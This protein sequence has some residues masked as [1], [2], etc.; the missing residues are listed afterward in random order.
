MHCGKRPESRYIFHHDDSCATW[1]NRMPSKGTTLPRLRSVAAA[2]AILPRL[3]WVTYSGRNSFLPGLAVPSPSVVLTRA[4]HTMTRG[5]LPLRGGRLIDLTLRVACLRGALGETSY[6]EIRHPRDSP[7]WRKEDRDGCPQ[8]V[9]RVVSG[10]P[11]HCLLPEWPIG[12][13]RP[14]CVARI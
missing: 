9:K 10:V 3:G 2:R 5:P 13:S 11:G 14:Q 12:S 6:R 4:L 8:C 7:E 1:V